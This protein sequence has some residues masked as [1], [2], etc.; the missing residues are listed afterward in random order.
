MSDRC[1]KNDAPRFRSAGPQAQSLSRR[2]ILL[3]GT[4]FAAAS[5]LS[6]VSATRPAQAQQAPAP[7]GGS[8]PN[9]LVI[10]GD[11]IG[12]TNVSAYSMGLMGYRTP[13]I[14]RVAKEGMIFTDYYAEQSCTAGRSSFITGQATLRTGLSKVGIPGSPIGLQARDITIAEALKPLGYATGQFGKNH[15]GDRNE[16]LPTVHGF[17]EFLGNLYHLNAE[18]DPETFNYPRDPKFKELFGPRGVLRCKA[19]DVDD[20]TEQPRWGR[21]GK[22][23]IEDTGPLT[24]KRME[25]IDDETSAAAMDFIDRQVK[26]NK[27]FFC[28][29]NT[30]RMHFRTHVRAE[31]RDQPGLTARTEYADGMIEH[32]GTVGSLLRKLD[33]LGIVNNTI[34]IYTTDNGPHE[35][36]W[37][38]GAMTPFRSEK[39]TNWEG[40]FRVPCMIRWPGHIKAGE[41]SNEI[42]SGHDWFPTLLAAAGEPEI[43]NKLLTGYTAVGK[44]FK[45]HVDGYNQL[46]YL[47]GQEAKGARE[48]F[49]YF[50]DDG[51]LVSLRYANWKVVFAE[52]RAA[53]TLAVWG[54]PFTKLRMPKLYDLHADPFERADIT[55]NTYWDWVLDHGYIMAGA[56][57][58]VAQFLATFKEFPPSQ[59]AASF[60]IDQVMEKLKESI[61]D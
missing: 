35:N 44:T 3:A 53:G 22:Q 9:I 41:V 23:T 39:A 15:L 30:T 36:S 8:K 52:Q 18:E 61:G 47:T 2:N 13:N 54:E 20:P 49:F 25:T 38:D 31:H 24:R 43:K 42:V 59:R 21:V 1:E 33:E 32:D 60:T 6:S 29:M 51:D 26:A 48:G 11:D 34:V 19:T 50:N 14:D 28:W 17:D 16:Y 10:M 45:V 27:P 40:A 5:A 46:P 4:T 37:P 55:S 7:A 56:Q 12:L 57:A 58:G